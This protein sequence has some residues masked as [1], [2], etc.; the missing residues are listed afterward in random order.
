MAKA[1]ET[2]LQNHDWY[3]DYSEDPGVWRRGSA[4]L[5][6]LQAQSEAL[7]CPF[8]L[9]E[10]RMFVYDMIVENFEE[11]EPRRYYRKGGRSQVSV[12][13]YELTQPSKD[14]VLTTFTI[15]FGDG[16]QVDIKVCNSKTENERWWEAVLFDKGREIGCIIG[17]NTP[18]LGV[19]N[20]TSLQFSL[21]VEE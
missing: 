21:E 7:K 4:E 9:N 15:D 5:K 20:F 6:K 14:D 17:E 1:F 8:G 12:S 11:R 10:L 13:L 18:I 3:Y 16:M 2:A 19:Y